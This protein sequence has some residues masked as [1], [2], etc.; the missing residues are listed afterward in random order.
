[1]FNLKVIS[2]I[3]KGFGLRVSLVPL[4]AGPEFPKFGGVHIQSVAIRV[5]REPG[6][7]ALAAVTL[8]RL[9]DPSR[10]EDIIILFSGFLDD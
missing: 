7:N 8:M 5:V 2:I 9:K 10:Q 3:I 6:I 1:M 4:I